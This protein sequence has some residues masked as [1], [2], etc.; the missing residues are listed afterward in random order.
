MHASR[1]KHPP[2]L[3]LFA[4]SARLEESNRPEK[5]PASME[6]VIAGV[7]GLVFGSLLAWLLLRSHASAAEARF[8]LTQKELLAARAD[9]ARLMEEQKQLV[10]ARARLE[11][12][13]EAERK[14]SAE[15]LELLSR[16]GADLQ[17]AFKALA[18]EALKNNASSFLDIAK[19]TLS[20]FQ[21]EAQGDLKARQQA[22]NLGDR[23]R[24]VIAEGRRL[25]GESGAAAMLVH[26][27]IRRGPRSSTTPVGR[28][29][30]H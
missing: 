17:N 24:I 30:A 11:S 10:A 3:V 14:T 26:F 4:A 25:H 5:L 22:D 9:L 2:Q 13:L 20:R 6:L 7:V 27:S 18:A 19:E 1:G 29:K 16:A 8:S 15:K 21:T 28:A 12:A 23:L